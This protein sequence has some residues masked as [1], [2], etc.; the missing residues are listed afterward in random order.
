MSII[1][2]QEVVAPWTERYSILIWAVLILAAGGMAWVILRS[3]KKFPSVKS[4][5]H[6]PDNAVSLAPGQKT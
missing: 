2:P 6:N 4:A 3:L 1:P 5:L